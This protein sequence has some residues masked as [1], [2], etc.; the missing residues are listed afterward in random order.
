MMQH[1]FFIPKLGLDVTPYIEKGNRTGVH[2]LLR[3]EWA[4]RTISEQAFNQNILDIACGAGY[5][6][7]LL[8]HPHSFSKRHRNGL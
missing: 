1:E 6:S 2:H 3:Y 4:V 7:Y 8:C 5:G